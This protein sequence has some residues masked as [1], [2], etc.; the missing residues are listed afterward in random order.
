MKI[1][2]RWIFVCLYTIG[3]ITITPFLPQLI[4]LASAR[5]SGKGVSL[6]VLKI[7]ILI[8]LVTLVVTIVFLILRKNKSPLHLIGI[9]GILL[10]SFII[11]QILPNPYEYTHLPEYAILSMLIVKAIDRRETKRI[12]TDRCVGINKIKKGD[13]RFSI[14][15]NIYL[16]SGMLTGIIGIGDEIYQHFLPNRF[17]TLYDIFLNILGGILGLLVFWGVKK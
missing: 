7:E 8:A 11:Y 10:M 5:W 16:K 17:F 2:Q 15:K 13:T 14:I 3:I 12:E 4:R 6:F 1:S 9:G